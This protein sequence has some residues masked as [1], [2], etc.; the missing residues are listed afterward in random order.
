[1]TLLASGIMVEQ[2]LKAA[3][4]LEAQGVSV[5]VIDLFRIKPIHE[6]IPALLSGRPV[7]T[8]ENHNRIGGLGSSICELMAMDLTTPVH[9][10]GIE[11]SFGQVG[12]QAYLMDVYGLTAE[13]IVKQ[14]QLML[15]Q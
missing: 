6:D 4:Q 3:D 7:L 14:A 12:Q 9:R 2:A 13:H 5:Q 1:M 11:E 8:V 15:Q 10:I